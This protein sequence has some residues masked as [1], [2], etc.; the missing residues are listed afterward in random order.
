MKLQ[1]LLMSGKSIIIT[2]LKM[3]DYQRPDCK[4]KAAFDQI[5]HKILRHHWSLLR[6]IFRHHVKKLTSAQSTSCG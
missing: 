2:S 5:S 1:K 3:R 4:F 6:S